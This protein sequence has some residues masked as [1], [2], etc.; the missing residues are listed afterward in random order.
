MAFLLPLGAV[1]AAAITV[2]TFD[3]TS[4]KM[5]KRKKRKSKTIA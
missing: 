5:I 2:K 3:K 1:L 4:K